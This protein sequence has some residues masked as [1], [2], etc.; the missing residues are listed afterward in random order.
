MK[1]FYA[2]LSL[3]LVALMAFSC[4]E[5]ENFLL[6]PEDDTEL[7]VDEGVATDTYHFPEYERMFSVEISDEVSDI[8]VHV[9][10]DCT[11]WI[12]ARILS[13]PDGSGTKRSLF[14]LVSEN[15]G[16]SVR[17]GT[18]MLAGDSSSIRK[19][20]CIEQ[21]GFGMNG[22][23]KKGLLDLYDATSGKN[24]FKRKGDEDLRNLHWNK[25]MPLLDFYGITPSRKMNASVVNPE[26]DMDVYYGIDDRWT[27]Y[28]PFNGLRGKIPESFWDICKYF[29]YITINNCYLQDSRLSDKVWHGNLEGID[30]DHTYIRGELSSAITKAINLQTV[31]FYKCFITGEIPEDITVLKN[32]QR[33][34]FKYC[35]LTGGLPGK[36]GDLSALQELN[37]HGNLNFGG[38]LPES[39]YDLSKL[40]KFEATYTR[41]GGEL[42]HRIAEMTSL[43]F[44]YVSCCEFEG[45]VPEELGTLK[46]FVFE[47]M[48]NYFTEIPEFVRY[49]GCQ[50]RWILLGGTFP[51][52]VPSYQRERGIGRPDDMYV[53]DRTR[54][55]VMT[56][57]EYSD[58]F[59]IVTNESRYIHYLPLP[60]WAHIRYNIVGWEKYIVGTRV[61][62]P[63]WPF[64]EDLQYPADEYYYDKVAKAWCHPDLEYP[65]R[66]YYFD[67]K[68]WVH[69]ASCPWDQPYIY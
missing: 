64:A 20:V 52:G 21:L 24:W 51:D 39:F 49:S 29:T 60:V 13:S 54:M 19:A 69:D 65:A 56:A 32:L 26:Y 43:K 46:R 45:I 22:S 61:K 48:N 8:T 58:M 41:I 57:D 36:I 12:S 42:S 33:I 15:V 55:D 68:D 14:V 63:E 5:K 11:D 23:M 10:D 27:I 40:V 30:F 31:S 2:L 28:L 50:N 47:G 6:Q 7:P 1:N 18:V 38:T 9:T 59:P 16:T 4:E 66:E 35:D 3:T 17:K 53:F 34:D 44:L 37:L 25:D 67:G 62:K